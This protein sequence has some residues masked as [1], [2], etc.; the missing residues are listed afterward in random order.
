MNI[1]K[2]IEK[3]KKYT[4]N[5]EIHENTLIFK[6]VQHEFAGAYIG[7]MLNDIDDSRSFEVYAYV[8]DKDIIACPLLFK[9]FTDIMLATEYYEK[10]VFLIENN[11]TEYIL[12]RLKM[13]VWEKKRPPKRPQNDTKNHPKTTW[14]SHGKRTLL[15]KW[16]C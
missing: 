9:K 4:S 14:N 8:K 15:L 10:I 5:E 13:G 16:W 11:E 1:R 6:T 12:N 7:V 3:L 2:E